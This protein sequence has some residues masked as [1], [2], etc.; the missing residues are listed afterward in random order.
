[1]FVYELRVQRGRTQTLCKPEGREGTSRS[2]KRPLHRLSETAKQLVLLSVYK[3]YSSFPVLFLRSDSFFGLFSVRNAL[4]TK[5]TT[6]L[7][8]SK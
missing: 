6:R 2:E 8:F 3:R 7:I 4:I 5:P 1:M